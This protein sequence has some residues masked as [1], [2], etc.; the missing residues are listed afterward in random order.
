MIYLTSYKLFE[1]LSLDFLCPIKDRLN[2]MFNLTGIKFQ[3]EN[4]IIKID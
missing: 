2:E 3:L 1:T 4:N